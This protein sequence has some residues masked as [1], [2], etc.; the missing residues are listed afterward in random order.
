MFVFKAELLITNEADRQFMTGMAIVSWPFEI[1]GIINGDGAVIM[2]E[3]V[4]DGDRRHG[5]AMDADIDSETRAIWHSHP[6]G[7]AKLSEDDI[8]CI[9]A[10]GKAGYT[11]RWIIVTPTGVHEY[12]VDLESARVSAT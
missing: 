5:F 10:L 7:P 1:C 2:H 3:N 9:D 12:E 4:L 8:Q 6:R 11:P